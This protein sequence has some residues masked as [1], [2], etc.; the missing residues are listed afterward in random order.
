MKNF[1]FGN[2]SLKRLQTCHHD[3]QKLMHLTLERTEEDFTILQ[4][5]RTKEEQDKF[6]KEGKSKVKFPNSKH[7][8]VPSMAVDIA[9]Y[10]ID[11]NDIARFHKLAKV[12]LNCAEE[13]NLTVR[14]GGDWDMDGDTSDQTFNDLPHFELCWKKYSDS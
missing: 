4:G 12:V 2:S 8:I 7:N 11:W 6:Y 14:W 9:P 1:K 13:L 5:V 10:P 3:L